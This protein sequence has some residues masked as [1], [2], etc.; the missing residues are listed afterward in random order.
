MNLEQR[1][2]TF[3]ATAQQQPGCTP[4]DNKRPVH[5]GKR[6]AGQ[7]LRQLLE[8]F[9]AR[10]LPPDAIDAWLQEGRITVD[11]KL[12]TPERV[13]VLGNT[14][15]VTYRN[16]VEPKIAPGLRLVAEDAAVMVIDKPAPLPVHPCGRYNKN[17]LTKLSELAWP[18]LRLRL[19]HRLDAQTTGL[20]VLAKSPAVAQALVAQFSERRVKKT[21]LARVAGHPNHDALG[22]NA[23]IAE[24]PGEAGRRA[25]DS[26][27]LA[28]STTVQVVARL[29]D[30]TSLLEV[31]PHTGRTHQIRLHL[32]HAGHAIVGDNDYGNAQPD[33]VLCLHA[34][35][36]SLLHPV[37]KQERSYETA[38][39]SWW[40]IS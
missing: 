12:V 23:A 40:P 21:Y 33:D 37:A 2:R 17:T 20:M 3:L 19:V 22:L 31:V 24:A 30:G 13:L 15:E 29:A 32:A 26:T 9:D 38:L 39:P 8:G 11:G 36:I 10:D 25:V 14:V 6:F 7:T 5:I 16:A 18:D 28:A 4:Y 27:G 35:R 1:A 34:H